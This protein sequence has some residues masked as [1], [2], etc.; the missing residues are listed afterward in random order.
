[1]K[2]TGDRSPFM[3]FN[4]NHRDERTSTTHCLRKSLKAILCYLFRL[5]QYLQS[6]GQNKKDLFSLYILESYYHISSVRDIQSDESYAPF[7]K[8]LWLLSVKRQLDQENASRMKTKYHYPQKA[9]CEIF[10]NLTITFLDRSIKILTNFHIKKY[11]L[12]LQSNQSGIELIE[13]LVFS[14]QWTSSAT[15]GK[16]MKSLELLLNR[17]AHNDWFK[18]KSPMK[19]QCCGLYSSHLY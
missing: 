5:Q 13:R 9:T 14:L 16:T 18:L 19:L 1:M 15:L 10:R 7:P 4:V 12:R 11:I 3:I 8:Y 6:W 17:G 2:H